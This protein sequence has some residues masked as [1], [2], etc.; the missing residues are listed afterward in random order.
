VALYFDF[1][2]LLKMLLGV[3]FDAC[4]SVLP[5]SFPSVETQAVKITFCNILIYD[6][7]GA[8]SKRNQKLESQQQ[9]NN[10]TRG[11]AS[12]N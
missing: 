2:L 1:P 3:C 12:A 4:C 10:K 8:W 9:P 7:D 5:L 6:I 11:K